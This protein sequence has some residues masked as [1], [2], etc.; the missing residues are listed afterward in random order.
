M[1]Q[2][3]HVPDLMHGLGQD[4]AEEG[5][6]GGGVVAGVRVESRESE[7]G[8]AASECGDAEGGAEPG[9]EEVAAEEGEAPAAV[10]G[11]V[12]H[13]PLEDLAGGVLPASG[14]E[15]FRAQRCG[16]IQRD[17]RVEAG[18][19]RLAQPLGELRRDVAQRQQVNGGQTQMSRSSDS[20]MRIERAIS[21]MG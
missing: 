4:A 7:D 14:I 13:E 17:G 9:D 2:A 18:L 12:T 3:G 16:R 15:P 20:A 19:E 6:A 11:R 10:E 21:T 1:V 5:V 8:A